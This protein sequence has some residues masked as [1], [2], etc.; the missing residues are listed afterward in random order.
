MRRR[1]ILFIDNTKIK[2]IKRRRCDLYMNFIL[3]AVLIN[4]L[5]GRAYGAFYYRCKMPAINRKLLRSLI[6]C[7]K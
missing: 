5:T 3:I 4:V 1:C 2:T 7:H 6:E